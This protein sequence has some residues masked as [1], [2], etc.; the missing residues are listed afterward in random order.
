MDIAPYIP[1]KTKASGNV[2]TLH[3]L[4]SN[5]TPF[6]PSPKAIEAYKQSGEALEL[7]P[8]VL[9][10]HCVKRLPQLTAFMPI[11]LFAAQ[12]QMRF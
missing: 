4:S 8:E 3:K 10:P 7:Y 6:G 12:A 5:E 11:K 2:A 1:G 9:Q